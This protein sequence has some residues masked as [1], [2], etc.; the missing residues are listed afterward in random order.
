[1]SNISIANPIIGKAEI[2]EVINVLKSGELS[3]GKWVEKFE[4]DFAKFTNTDFAIAASNGTTALYLSLL[5]LGVGKGNEVITTPFTFIASTNAILY[6]GA[7]PSFVDIDPNTFNINANLVEEKITSKTRAILPV[8][9]FGLPSDMDKILKI[10]KKYNLFIIEDAAQAHGAKIGNQ[11][12][13]SFGDVAAF[14][15]YSTKNMTTGEGGMVT[16]NNEAVAKKIKMLRNHGMKKRYHHEML[17]FNFRMTNIQAA[18]GIHQL[19]K[20]DEF[21]K[22]RLKNANIL[23]KGL[24]SIKD[25]QTP[26]IPPGFTHVFHQ[27]TILVK[28]GAKKRDKLAEYLDSNGVGT[29]IYYPIPTYKQKSMQKIYPALK[30]TN[31][32]HAANS[33][34]SLPIHPLVTKRELGKMVRLIKKFYKSL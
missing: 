32:E 22:R 8:H 18:I 34:I 2:D 26:Y 1:M 9:L 7:K 17:G 13:G 12:T 14:S 3:Q 10:A 30:L 27:Y 29:M 16:T 23:S 6:T 5:A 15:F 21:N 25:I 24:L 11:I 28:E 4:Q 20:L 19:K 33:V 31:T